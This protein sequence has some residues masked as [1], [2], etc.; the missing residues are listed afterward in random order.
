MQ[1]QTV[2]TTP[3]NQRVFRATIL[4]VVFVCVS[5][6]AVD[7]WLTLRARDEKLYQATLANDNLTHAVSRQ[8]DG[9]FTETARILGTLVFELE[10][11]KNDAATIQHLQPVLVNYVATTEQLQSIFVFDAS[12]HGVVN[13]E[14]QPFSLVNNSDRDY[15]VHHRDSL[16]SLRYVGKP[17]I[18]RSTGLWVVPVSQRINGPQ[19]EFA[20]VVVATIPVSYIRQL[21]AQYEIGQQGAIALLAEDGSL[22]ARLPY[23]VDDLHRK[24]ANTAQY[25]PI[26]NL[27]YGHLMAV[28][29]IDGVERLV[30]FRHLKNHPL[31]L[32]VALSKQEVLQSWRAATYVETGWIVALCV[33]MGALGGVVIRSVRAR[34]KVEIRLRHTRDQLTTANTQLAQLA[35]HDGLTGLPNRRYFDESLAREFAQSLRTRRPLAL[36]MIDVD[37][38]KNY[39]DAY[40]H[41][42]GDQCLRVIAECIQAAVR[43]PSDF[44]ARYGGEELAVL[45]PDT[46]AAGAAGVAEA[47]RAAVD[48]L[49]LPFPHDPAG[50]VTISAGVAVHPFSAEVTCAGDLLAAAD[51]ALYRA[52]AAGRNRVVSV[53]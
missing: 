34:F 18:S 35:H 48:R 41:P 32:T 8:L 3:S 44:V 13:S 17:I 14:A 11:T 31:L 36:I 15:F 9:M 50:Q 27:S 7:F 46:D 42:E 43:R 47:V 5:L 23:S 19:G 1:I 30:S 52:K 24:I 37:H 22:M 40:G 33:C 28:S 38:F 6:L 10:R 4:F 2:K 16:S 45:L 49:Q 21:M 25:K 12:G 26:Q 39:N 29:P 51:R 20:G 53:S